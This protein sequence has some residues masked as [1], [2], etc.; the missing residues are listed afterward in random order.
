MN[1]LLYYLPGFVQLPL[2]HQCSRCAIEKDGHRRIHSPS[3]HVLAGSK[4]ASAGWFNL[5]LCIECQPFRVLY[6][7][8]MH[9]ILRREMH[10]CLLAE[11]K[12]LVGVSTQATYQYSQSADLTVYCAGM[13]TALIGINLYE[14]CGLSRHRR[15]CI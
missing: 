12:R 1:H 3:E 2:D 9:T 15:G 14:W 6:D 4:K 10:V 8:L 5:S 11:C 13:R 7:C